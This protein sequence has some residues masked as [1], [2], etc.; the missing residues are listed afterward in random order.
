[1]ASGIVVA[2]V[3]IVTNNNNNK[4]VFKKKKKKVKKINKQMHQLCIGMAGAG[5]LKRVVGWLGWAGL[6]G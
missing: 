3:V 5:G 6:D 1:M 2:C 4:L